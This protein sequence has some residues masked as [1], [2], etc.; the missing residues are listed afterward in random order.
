MYVCTYVTGMITLNTCQKELPLNF[1]QLATLP[2]RELYLLYISITR[3]KPK[4]LVSCY[5]SL[6]M[7]AGSR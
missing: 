1:T 3:L 7:A 5:T 2:A 6:S 4:L